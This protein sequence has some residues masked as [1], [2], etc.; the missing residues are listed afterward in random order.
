MQSKVLLLFKK[1]FIE[2]MSTFR[3]KGVRKDI[4]GLISSTLLLALVYGVFI[5]VFAEFAGI[6]VGLTFGNAA[7]INNRIYELTTAAF[8]AVFLLNIIVGVTR[9]HAF[10]SKGEDS[11]VLICQPIS[12]WS[13]FFYK[14]LKVY[15]SQVL[16]S[17]LI[18]IPA[19]IVIDTVS[20]RIL[21]GVDY[22]LLMLLAT[23]IAPVISCA[24]SALLAVPYTKLM[25]MLDSKFILCLLG[26]V[27][28]LGAG[29]VVYSGFLNVLTS[30]LQNGEIQFVLDRNTVRTIN[31]VASNCYPAN[32]LANFV[33]GKDIL[34]SILVIAGASVLCGGIA[35]FVVQRLY[36]KIVQQ[37]LEGRV[38]TFSQK[39][40]CKKRSTFWTLFVKEFLVVL[41][42]PSYAFQY[43]AT[44]FT[45]PFMVY[46]CAN[47]MQS[48]MK[49]ITILDCNFAIII[50]VIAMF[51]ILTNNFCA[52]N[53]SRDGNMF[54]MLKT[55]PV[56]A[57]DI[58]K[59]KFAFCGVVSFLSVLASI[60]V[61]VIVGLLTWWQAIFALLVG[62]MLS[63]AGIAF[64]TRR[65]LANPAFPTGA[66]QEITEGNKNASMTT[67]VG[68][69][70]SLLVGGGELA[71]SAVLSVTSTQLMATLVPMAFVTV[72]V[73]GLFAWSLIYLR[74][75][76]DR[77]Y[78][79]TS[80]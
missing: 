20:G 13:I 26:Y 74:K 33:F 31:A 19:S 80:L 34:L 40:V 62:C 50:F 18:L 17:A 69:I 54:A 36:D 14:L 9:I 22:Y 76:L 27:L 28:L 52:T 78:F 45:L 44:T 60:V 42:T 10:V 4:V 5:Y 70:V 7:E 58:V 49:T 59:A 68:L 61:L 73:G 57:A 65:D 16:S 41:R 37:R 3:Q 63:F 72:M 53:I 12:A 21:G 67:L 30:L 11:D 35:Y 8:A 64:S 23:L 25:R 51:S 2:R 77:L 71:L 46:V 32:L 75:G 79:E 66:L 15:L 48:M 39:Y 47:L 43:F 24:I 29:F 38:K 1:D 56:R 6:Y 55:M